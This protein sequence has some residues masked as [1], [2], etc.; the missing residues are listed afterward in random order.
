MFDKI[1]NNYNKGDYNPDFSEN[2]LV[3]FLNSQ[4]E[5]DKKS[6]TISADNIAKSL[7]TETDPNGKIVREVDVI[8]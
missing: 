8:L 7:I 5:K 6:G 1:K 3:D 2:Q 4:L